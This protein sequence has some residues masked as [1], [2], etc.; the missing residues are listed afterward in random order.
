MR[1]VANQQHAAGQFGDGN[2]LAYY[3]FITDDGLAFIHPVDAPFVDHNLIA[4]RVVHG[5][6]H[7]GNHLLLILTQ[8]RAEQLTQT[9]VFLLVLP[10]HQKFAVF[11]QQFLA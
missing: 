5:G 2:N 9:R 3:A 10:Q 4:V 11:Q 1:G 8:R 7:L 6:D